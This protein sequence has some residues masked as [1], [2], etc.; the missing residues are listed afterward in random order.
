MKNIQGNGI[1][2]GGQKW[3]FFMSGNAYR[4]D[5][6][7]SQGAMWWTLFRTRPE[8]WCMHMYIRTELQQKSFSCTVK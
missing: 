1:T 5:I 8:P 7:F 4:G 6:M 3:I 2:S